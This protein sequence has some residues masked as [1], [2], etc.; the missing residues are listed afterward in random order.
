MKTLKNQRFFVPR[1]FIKF[2][3]ASQLYSQIFIY[4]LTIILIS[5]ILAYGYNAVQNFKNRAEQVSCLKFKNDL[6]NAIESISS[7]FGSV[8]R[9][10]LQ[11]CASYIQ[12]CFVET[13][14]SPNLPSNVNP[15][16]KGELLSNTGNNVF[17]IDGGA[18]ESF[19]VGKISVEPDALCIKSTNSKISLRLEGKGNHVLLGKW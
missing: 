15:F 1:K 17:L 7:D 10:E 5:F 14:E 6:V 18:P 12:A 3:A 4:V 19:H 9:K 8:K 13:F 11:L 16:I 2:S